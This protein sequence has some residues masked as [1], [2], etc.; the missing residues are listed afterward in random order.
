MANLDYE[1]G[2][3]RD[4]FIN[5]LRDEGNVSTAAFRADISRQTAYRH[6]R[7]FV[8]FREQWEDALEEATDKLELEARRRALEGTLKP[9]YY[10]GEE[11]GKVREYSDTLMIYLLKVHRYE[12]QKPP[13]RLEHTGKDGGPIQTEEKLPDVSKLSDDDLR[14]L[15]NIL[16]GAGESPDGDGQGTGG[17]PS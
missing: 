16:S 1:W 14:T 7:D 4:D 6:R 9:V 13:L 3:W 10:Q 12:K 17:A 2:D 11:V 5:A 8:T 15:Q